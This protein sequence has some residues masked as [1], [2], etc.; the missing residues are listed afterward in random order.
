[1]I[2]EQVHT[3]N[4]PQPAYKSRLELKTFFLP[5]DLTTPQT[6]NTF[7]K[8]AGY[9]SPRRFVMAKVW[10]RG[11]KQVLA[12]A[13]GLSRQHLCDILHGRRQCSPKMAKR[14]EDA[15]E[16]Q[17]LKLK[18]GD[19][20]YPKESERLVKM[21]ERHA[22]KDCTDNVLPGAGQQLHQERSDALSPV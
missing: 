15:C 12:K 4:V 2:W 20:L 3:S 22:K 19:W 9:I 7:R 18:A 8:L 14:L 17:G 1:L 10:K 5:T 11:Q 13:A 6:S 21:G 16:K